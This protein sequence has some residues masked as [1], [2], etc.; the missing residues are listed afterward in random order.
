M[1]KTE[2][3]FRKIWYCLKQKQSCLGITPD[4]D[5]NLFLNQL[6]NWVEVSGGSGTPSLPLN[7]VQYNNAGSFGGDSGFTRNPT[8]FATTISALSAPTTGSLLQLTSSLVTVGYRNNSSSIVSAFAAMSTSGEMRF[9]TA[10]VDYR[11]KADGTSLRL[12]D[13]QNIHNS[14]LFTINDTSQ[15]FTF[16][17]GNIALSTV[18]TYADD[19]AAALGGVPVNGIYRETGTGYLKARVV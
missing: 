19:A 4:G 18:G 14:I 2:S 17:N 6:G 7:S 3:E 16:Q 15:Q 13:D 10:S 9:S 12:G 8:T 1:T 5:E 11:I